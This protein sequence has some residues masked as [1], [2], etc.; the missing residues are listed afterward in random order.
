M[1]ST[2]PHVGIFGAGAVGT[3]LGTR[4]SAA[5]VRVTLLGR[6]PLQDLRE[7]IAAHDD[8]GGVHVLSVDATITDDPQALRGV[9][10]CLVCVKTRDVEDA[11]KTL[12]RVLPEH[13]IA[14][15][16]Q[17][18]LHSRRRLEQRL[19]RRVASATVG[20]NV[21]WAGPAAVE[22]TLPGPLIIQRGDGLLR[23]LTHAFQ[24][25]GLDAQSHPRIDDVMAGKLLLNTNNGV[26]GATGLTIPDVMR[27]VDARWVFAECIREGQRV[28][29]A[30]GYRPA[31]IALLGP[32]AL[33]WLLRLPNAVMRPLLSC[34]H[35]DA[36]ADAS[37]MQDLRRG[38]KTEIG[39][40]NG[41]IVDLS[42][43]HG[44]PAPVNTIVTWIVRGHETAIDR[45]TSPDYWSPRILR[46]RCENERRL[47]AAVAT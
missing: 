6:R 15:S 3:Y 44:V 39:E 19:P 38:N 20:F 5:G 40:L 46:R 29:E 31:T 13:A 17:N 28:L 27:D 21:G 2:T 22:Q 4:L 25:A 41:A 47:V 8:E 11:A 16:L 23:W 1:S 32:R 45:G 10:V 35:M 33:S 9:D 7:P 36:A 42:R 26:C 37:T 34:W 24:D 12:Y 14:V 30:A 43:T 18:G